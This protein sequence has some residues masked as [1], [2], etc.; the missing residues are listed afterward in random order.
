M[1]TSHIH[2]LNI[3]SVGP[4]ELTVTDSGTGPTYLLLHGGGG[5]QTVSAFA[6]L[7]TAT[8]ARVIAPVHP[9]FGGTVRPES[10]S[11][12][13]QLAELYVALLDDLNL[14]DVTVIGNSLSA[15]VA[16]EIALRHSSRVSGLIIIDGVGIEVTDHPI[17]DFFSIPPDQIAQYSFHDSEKFRINPSTL[18]PAVRAAL[19]GN[20]ASLAA[21][22]GATMSDPS[23]AARLGGVKIPTLVLWGDADKIVDADYGRAYAA[24]IPG[25]R[26]GLLTATGHLPHV[27]T[28]EAVLE[29]IQRFVASDQK[30]ED[31]PMWSYEYTAETDLEPQVI[32]ASMRALRTGELPSANGDQFDLQ[33]TFAVG[34]TILTRPEGVNETLVSRITELVE[35]QTFAIETVFNGLTLLNQYNISRTNGNATQI[36]LVLGISGPGADKMAPEIGARIS[37]DYPEAMKHLID[38]ARRNFLPSATADSERRLHQ[39]SESLVAGGQ[40]VG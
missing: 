31:N 32:W 9:G 25:A 29:A 40:R 3:D 2:A 22:A 33:G 18:P 14:T 16:A 39:D 19:P 8:G 36:T 38:I 23:L 12:I 7:L 30:E 21:Y 4:V 24:A 17:I 28:P 10:V 6:D 11:T 26:F 34:S 37:A 13:Q 20:R 27:E 15:W 35:H 1:S 5:P